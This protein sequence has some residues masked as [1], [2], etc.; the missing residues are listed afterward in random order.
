MA[1]YMLA[2]AVLIAS[3][4]ASAMPLN[5]C[6][7]PS[8]RT[9]VM[10]N[11]D[12]TIQPL[13]DTDPVRFVARQMLNA[14][15]VVL[16]IG[17]GQWRNDN[18]RTVIAEAAKYPGKVTHVYVVDEM[19]QCATGPCIGRDDALVSE[20]TRIAHTYGFKTVAII[21]PAVVFTPGFVLPE[22]DDIAVD[23]YPAALN[24]Q[25]D[26]GDC[27]FNENPIANQVYCAGKKL[28]ALGHR[29]MYG[30]PFQGF[31]ATTDTHAMRMAQLTMQR[32]AIDNASALG[33]DALMSWGC[34]LG[35]PE[36]KAEPWLVPLCETQYESLV[37]P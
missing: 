25:V 8:D 22:V 18:F 1:N 26:L 16:W 5:I 14:G 17:Q 21:T 6:L 10:H 12:S 34:H 19:N 20:A 15:N 35:D 4:G 29:G 2:L 36:I 23:A 33:V 24:F 31:G 37:T 3:A 28:R 27:K 9:V 13:L 32:E 7:Q 11:C 30:W